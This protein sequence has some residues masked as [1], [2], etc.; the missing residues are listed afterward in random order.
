MEVPSIA[1]HKWPAIR[2]ILAP[3]L[4]FEQSMRRGPGWPLLPA[5]LEILRVRASYKLWLARH[6]AAHLIALLHPA[7]V[8]WLS[9]NSAK[10]E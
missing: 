8:S 5:E 2:D 3:S 6:G 10:F 4:A 7:F 1:A 9:A